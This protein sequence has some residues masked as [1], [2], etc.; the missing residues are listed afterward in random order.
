MAARGAKRATA[1]PARK[2]KKVRRKADLPAQA[3]MSKTEQAMEARLASLSP[4]TQRYNILNTAIGFKRSWLSLAKSLYEV[5]QKKAYKEWGYRTLHAYA[6]HEL[7]LRKDT[8]MKLLRSYGFL[9]THERRLLDTQSDGGSVVPLPS[10]Q[11]LDVLA[12]ARDNP[13]LSENDY[14]EVRAQVFEADPSPSQVRKLVR[15]RAPE[16]VKKA[17]VDPTAQLR[18]CLALAERLY[19][20]LLEQEDLPQQIPSS[21]EEAIGGLRKLLDD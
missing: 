8:A 17:D 11:A 15:E 4:G 21:V 3:T 18:K 2:T 5:E 13:Y 9:E 12:E 14:K 20:L 10:Y 19:G 1:A 16:P 6:N 7:H